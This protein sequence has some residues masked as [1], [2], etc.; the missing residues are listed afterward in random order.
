MVPAAAEK[1]QIKTYAEAA[2]IVIK[3]NRRV[4]EKLKDK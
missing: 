3:T 4:L 2:E 1:K